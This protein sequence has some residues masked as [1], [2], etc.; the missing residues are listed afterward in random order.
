MTEILAR[1]QGYDDPLLRTTNAAINVS[2][3]IGGVL[4]IIEPSLT[5][6][7][8]VWTIPDV[9]GQAG[10]TIKPDAGMRL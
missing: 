5:K 1:G 8:C 3:N 4:V 9:S 7:K 10:I 2:V 6:D